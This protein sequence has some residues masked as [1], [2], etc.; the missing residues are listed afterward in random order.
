MAAESSDIASRLDRWIS[1]GIGAVLSVGC[2]VAAILNRNWAIAIAGFGFAAFLPGRYFS[3]T[4]FF[5]PVRRGLQSATRSYLSMPRWVAASELLG[6]LLFIGFL[7]VA[8]KK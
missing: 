4:P 6:I 5:Q 2:L 8:W 7:I 1:V 3:P